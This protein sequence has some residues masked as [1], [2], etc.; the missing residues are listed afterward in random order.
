MLPAIVSMMERN[1]AS[2]GAMFEATGTPSA[3]P[4]GTTID[5]D[6]GEADGGPRRRR[7]INIGKVSSIVPCIRCGAG[8]VPA[9]ASPLPSAPSPLPP[10]AFGGCSPDMP[11]I[12]EDD[13]C[14]VLMSNSCCSPLVSIPTS[15]SGGSKGGSSPPQMY[16][17]HSAASGAYRSDSSVLIRIAIGVCF[18]MPCMPSASNVFSSA[19]L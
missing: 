1:S 8:V 5:G 10:L 6:G 15:L 13:Y 16:A 7:I 4:S 18:R 11:A 14:S 3:S 19:S 9:A 2:G 17:S 12:C